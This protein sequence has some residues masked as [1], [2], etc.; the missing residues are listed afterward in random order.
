MGWGNCGE[1]SNGRPIGY[2]HEATCDHVGCNTKIDRGLS[3][4]CGGMHGE[5][6]ISC[7]K[8]FC[9]EHRSNFI[10]HCEDTFLICDECA[11]ILL[12]SGDWYEDDSEGCIMAVPYDD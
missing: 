11:N 1:D 3:Y 8:Y 5:D 6:E 12:E 2:C 9:E 4:A 7:E 10:V